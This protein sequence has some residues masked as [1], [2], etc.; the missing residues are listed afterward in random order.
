MV[1]LGQVIITTVRRL[2]IVLVLLSLA[3][4]SGAG[5][6]FA[7]RG[8]RVAPYP[9]Q[10]FPCLDDSGDG[11][12]TAQSSRVLLR[13]EWAADAGQVGVAPEGGAIA[14]RA[15]TEAEARRV[16]R[17]IVLPLTEPATAKSP[18][19]EKV[20]LLIG[21]S[22]KNTYWNGETQNIPS[23]QWCEWPQVAEM[24][25]RARAE[26]VY[27]CYADVHAQR[28]IP[29]DTRAAS[30]ADRMDREANAF[31]LHLGPRVEDLPRPRVPVIFRPPGP[32]D[33]PY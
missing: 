10:T 8:A 3:A 23:Y 15:T 29:I 26:V 20:A 1:S 14:W 31:G 27:D 21:C 22:A 30:I 6:L 7:F 2:C 33:D 11:W 13:I 28:L 18:F 12:L 9:P 17:S 16:A 25:I 24:P 32:G 19:S 5:L 4:L